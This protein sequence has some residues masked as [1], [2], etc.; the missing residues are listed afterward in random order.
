MIITQSKAKPVQGVYEIKSF[1]SA[2]RASIVDNFNRTKLIDLPSGYKV[3]DNILVV[4]GVV[5]RKVAP[6]DIHTFYV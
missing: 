4:S 5:V 1:P 6:S 3:G 2:G